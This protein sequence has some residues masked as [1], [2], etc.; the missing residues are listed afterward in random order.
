MYSEVT[1]DDAESNQEQR[2]KRCFVM[3][4]KTAWPFRV[5]V[6]DVLDA[7]LGVS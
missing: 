4:E 3:N 5:D 1:G 7:L 2:S 6:F